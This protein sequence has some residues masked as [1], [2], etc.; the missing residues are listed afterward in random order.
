VENEV[1]SRTKGLH[2]LQPQPRKHFMNN[3]F[4]IL[5]DNLIE[6]GFYSSL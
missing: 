1:A 2:S 4:R 6:L 5:I 3:R